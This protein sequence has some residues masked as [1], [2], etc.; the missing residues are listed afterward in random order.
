MLYEQGI[1]P[2]PYTY[3]LQPLRHF[4]WRFVTLQGYRDGLHGLRLS[5]LMAWYELQKYL[6]LRR[7]LSE[8]GG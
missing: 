6:T 1:R 2:S 7:I 8:Q 3:V 5:A 4:Y